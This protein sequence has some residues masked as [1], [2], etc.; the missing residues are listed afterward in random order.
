MNI[1][2]E[3]ASLVCIHPGGSVVLK[4]RQSWVT[5]EKRRV[6]VASDPEGCT[7][8]SCS[9]VVTPMVPCTMTLAVM[10]GY[11]MFV[12]VDGNPMCL[13]SVTGLTNGTLQG[14]VRYSVADPGQGFISASA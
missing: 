9:N 14:T 2:T 6:L 5:I 13:D 1:L 4:Q 3:D 8:R 12:R 11:S 7:I 10:T